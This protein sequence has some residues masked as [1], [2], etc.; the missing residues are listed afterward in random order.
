MNTSSNIASSGVTAPGYSAPTRPILLVGVARTL[1][2]PFDLHRAADRCNSCVVR[3]PGQ[4]GWPAGTPHG[5]LLEPSKSASCNRS[6][7]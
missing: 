5:V 6:A 1:G 7:V 4:H 2:E 3:F